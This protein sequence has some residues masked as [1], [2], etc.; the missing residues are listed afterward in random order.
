MLGP[1]ASGCTPSLVQGLTCPVPGTHPRPGSRQEFACIACQFT[2]GTEAVVCSFCFSFPPVPM[3]SFGMIHLNFLLKSVD[4]SGA[5]LSRRFKIFLRA[6]HAHGSFEL[7]PFHFYPQSNPIIKNLYAS[8]TREKVRPDERDH[9]D[10]TPV[11]R[12]ASVCGQHSARGGLAVC[13]WSLDKA[14]L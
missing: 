3:L 13:P 2:C 11:T 10:G 14:K 5:F 1:R 9:L 6:H 7:I 8:Y 4:F 12:G